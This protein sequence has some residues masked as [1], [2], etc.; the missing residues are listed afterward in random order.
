MAIEENPFHA[1]LITRGR[2]T[3]KDHSTTLLAVKHN[4]KI[5]FSRHRPNGDWF[6][7]AIV[8][9]EVVVKYNNSVLTGKA[10]QVTDEN[11]ERKISLLKYPHDDRGNEKRVVI[12]VTPDGQ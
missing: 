10:R 9:P 7:N 2:K 11:L 6:R 3:G 8:N 4:E 12:E 1:T 5:Y